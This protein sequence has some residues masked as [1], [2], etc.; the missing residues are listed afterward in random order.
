MEQPTVSARRNAAPDVDQIGTFLPVPGM[1]VL[2]VNA[3]LIRA[4]E[5]V[6][7]DTGVVALRDETLRTV[8]ELIDPRALKWIYLTH[9]DPDHSGALGSLLEEAPDARIITTYLGMGKLGLSA[10]VAPERV[11]LLNPG[12][13]IAVGDRTL[14]AGKPP[15]F[16]APETTWVTDEKTGVLFSSDCFG[17]VLE[18]PAADADDVAPGQ[19]RDGLVAWTGIDAPWFHTQTLEAVERNLQSVVKANP[20]FILGAHLPIARNK[21]AELAASLRAA[22][23]VAP[24]ASPD[25]EALE[26]MLSAA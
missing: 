7:V 20:E 13:R 8:R 2:P 18:A 23:S 10:P 4:A 14:R 22:H 5:P 21:A 24:A 12:Q 1:G 9:T 16:D 26:R 6:L 17:A 25:Q 11:W 3:F 15:T 19:L